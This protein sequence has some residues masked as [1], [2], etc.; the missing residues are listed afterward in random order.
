MAWHELLWQLV[1]L[2][3][4]AW[5]LA[6]LMVAASRLLWRGAGRW[7]LPWGANWAALGLAGCC[8]L[9]GGLMLLGE[10]GQMLTYAVLV[11]TNATVQWLLLHAGQK[12]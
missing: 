10:D 3:M 6:L 4:P 8:V 1:W 7:R 9:L 11:V 12:G 5:L 2:V